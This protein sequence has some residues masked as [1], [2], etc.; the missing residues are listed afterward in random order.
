MQRK[1]SIVGQH[2]EVCHLQISIPKLRTVGVQYGQ[3]GTPSTNPSIQLNDGTG[4]IHTVPVPIA[5]DFKHLGY[6]PTIAK[7]RKRADLNQFIR[8]KAM[9]NNV[10]NTIIKKSASPLCKLIALQSSVLNS[11]LWQA[12]A[13]PWSLK[14][15]RELDKPINRVCRHIT[16]NL[17]GF[18]TNLLYASAPGLALKRLS[19]EIQLRKLAMV[20]RGLT[21][22]PRLAAASH[23]L[24]LRAA[25]FYGL[26]PLPHQAQTFSHSPDNEGWCNSLLERLAECD[27]QLTYGMD[28]TNPLYNEQIMTPQNRLPSDHGPPS[29][30]PPR[31]TT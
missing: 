26:Q 19:D 12:Q 6:T 31:S 14:M 3:E 30:T 8:T 13:S 2:A 22:T 10:C 23:G 17:P 28:S 24:L 1:A 25:R 7:T 4:R 15:C 11:A 21:Y 5:N 27:L 20:N 16:K 29:S 18:P 9:L